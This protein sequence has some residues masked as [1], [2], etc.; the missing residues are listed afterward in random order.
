MILSRHQADIVLAEQTIPVER[1]TVI[2]PVPQP[3][4]KYLQHLKQGPRGR[5]PTDDLKKRIRPHPVVMIADNRH[6]I[7][8]IDG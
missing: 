3:A 5:Q 2:N 6:S 8:R 1:D 4:W 7:E